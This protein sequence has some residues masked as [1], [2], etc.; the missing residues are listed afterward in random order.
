MAIPLTIGI[1]VAIAI[2]TANSKMFGLCLLLGGDL[3]CRVA[4][5]SISHYRTRFEFLGVD[6][7]EIRHA[8]LPLKC[9]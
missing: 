1:V 4:A 8:S 7:L 9:E 2:A 6:P 5:V 3:L